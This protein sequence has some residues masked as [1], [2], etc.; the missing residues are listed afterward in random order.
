M[1]ID[2]FTLFPDAFACSPRTSIE[3]SPCVMVT[4]M[5]YRTKLA[6]VSSRMPLPARNVVGPIAS[7]TVWLLV[8][9]SNT[10]FPRM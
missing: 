6:L 3:N 1:L 8:N 9:G 4:G 10:S 5:A 2:V 7:P